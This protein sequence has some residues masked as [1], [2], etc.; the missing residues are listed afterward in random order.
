MRLAGLLSPL[1]F[2]IFGFAV[3]VMLLVG[4]DDVIHHRL[5][6][7]GLIQFNGYL[8]MLNW[9]VVALGWLITILGQAEGAMNRLLAV[10]NR[11]A[12][13][14]RRASHAAHRA[15]ER[16]GALRECLADPQRHGDPA[17]YLPGDPR[18]LAAWPSLARSA[19][20]SPA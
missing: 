6:L 1:M 14:R 18:R 11:A 3:M 12:G 5:T 9:P 7:G 20:A 2:V 16:R 13:H 15:G 8:M 4:G 19:A 10:Q 17:R